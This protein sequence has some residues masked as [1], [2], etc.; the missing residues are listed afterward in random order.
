[1]T[2]VIRSQ[3]GPAE[4]RKTLTFGGGGEMMGA[5][6]LLEGDDEFRLKQELKIETL[7][8]TWISVVEGQGNLASTGDSSGVPRRN[9]KD[10]SRPHQQERMGLLIQVPT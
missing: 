7:P 5:E 3:V 8:L 1:M 2:L 6:G 9:L 4:F 10:N